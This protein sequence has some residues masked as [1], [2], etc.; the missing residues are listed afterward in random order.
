[1]QM[2]ANRSEEGELDGLG[3]LDADVVEFKHI[4]ESGEI[5]LPQMGW[6]TVR[7]QKENPLFVNLPEGAEFYFL[8]SYYFSPTDRNDAL[9]I[10]HYGSD[11]V[12]AVNSRNIYGTQ[13]HPEKSHSWGVQLLKNFAEL[14]S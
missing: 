3:W 8:H 1:M 10:S 13:F 5:S 4:A 12:S 9:G 7:V 6:N 11:F 2:L 14:D